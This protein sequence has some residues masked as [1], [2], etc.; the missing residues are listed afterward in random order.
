MSH[1]ALL[2]DNNIVIAVY[3]GRQEDD[4]LE[5]ELSNRTGRTYRQ[6]SYNTHGGVHTQGGIPFR[7]NY[8]GIG[9]T[10]DE[11]RDAFIPPQPFPSWTLNEQT[12]LWDAPVP[13]PDDGG[14]YEWDEEAQQW[15]PASP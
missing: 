12:C 8:A 6:T 13:Y 5:Q 7:K 14:I 4:G 11:Q 2:D 1:F 9:Y 10:Y 15:A 3:R